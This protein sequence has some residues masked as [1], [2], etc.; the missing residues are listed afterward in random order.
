MLPE[1]SFSAAFFLVAATLAGTASPF[2]AAEAS[3]AADAVVA[4]VAVVRRRCYRPKEASMIE[5]VVVV[6]FQRW[7]KS[8]LNLFSF[9]RESRLHLNVDNQMD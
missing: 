3:V 6:D 9:S 4:A 7:M 2:F 5:V 1:T 8:L